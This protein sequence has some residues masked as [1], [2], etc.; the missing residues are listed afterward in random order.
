MIMVTVDKDIYQHMSQLVT[1]F[2][3]RD[4]YS[5]RVTGESILYII[6]R[7]LITR[8]REIPCVCLLYVISAGRMTV[9][10]IRSP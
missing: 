2:S 4:H 7:F 6:G 3:S 10:S 8:D 9:E 5:R 1:I